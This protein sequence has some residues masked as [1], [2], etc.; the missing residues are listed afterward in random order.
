MDST[1]HGRA[2]WRGAACGLGAAV[3]F[4]LSAPLAKRL[5][6]SVGPL[7]L[8]ALLYLGA[9]L[10]LAAWSVAPWRSRREA[11]LRRSDA[12]LLLGMIAAGGVLGPVAMLWGLGHLSAVA[13]SLLLNLEAVLTIAVAVAFFGEHLG[14]RQAGAT[15]L[16][17]LGA[18]LVALRGELRA[19]APGV[20]A[21][22]AACLCWALDNN[23]AA[24]LS[25]RDPVATVRWKALGAGAFSFALA[26]ALG[27]PLPTARIAIAALALGALGYGASIV[28][29]VYA[30]RLLGA[31]R[32]S[33]WFAT[34]PFVGALAAVPLLGERLRALDGAA[35][36]AIGLGLWL[37][38]RER[39]SHAH[40]HEPLEHDHLHVHDE[41]H[42][43]AHEVGVGDPGTGVAHSHPHR[44]APIHHAHP[45][46][47]DLHHHHDH[48]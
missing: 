26:R 23:L 32:E 34:A 42:Q 14:G 17:L 31:A 8:A 45:H 44:H 25:L 33:A 46:V 47:P 6:P 28:L 13:T 20:A 30:L 11:R 12:P 4:G 7:A 38:L 19:D 2:T 16:V 37:L 24:R 18:G 15:A 10:G 21:V 43:H 39:H 40:T 1:T 41:H 22:A 27:E 29:D 9:G 36:A 3:L 48:D 35:A 5:L